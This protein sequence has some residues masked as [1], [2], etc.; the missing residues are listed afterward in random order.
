M[1]DVTWLF[2]AFAVVWLAIGGYLYSLA[3][4]QKRLEQRISE[5]DRPPSTETTAR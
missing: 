4:R 3:A 2:V 1:N 5:L